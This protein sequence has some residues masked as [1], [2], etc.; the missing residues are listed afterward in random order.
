MVLSLSLCQYACRDPKKTCCSAAKRRRCPERAFVSI[1]QRSYFNLLINH[2][3]MYPCPCCTFVC[4]AIPWRLSDHCRIMEKRPLPMHSS[5]L[6]A[7]SPQSLR[8]RSATWTLARMS[9]YVVSPWSLPPSP[10]ASPWLE[11]LLQAQ[12]QSTR[13][14]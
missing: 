2:L 7:S 1:Y 13:T 14:I 11:D 4:L 8:A 10:F 9:N 5:P 6:M 3:D 12:K